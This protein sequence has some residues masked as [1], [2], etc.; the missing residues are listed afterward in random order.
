[1]NTII[2]RITFINVLLCSFLFIT[3]SNAQTNYKLKTHKI[4]IHG[5]S[6][7][8]DW[9]ESATKVEWS[10]KIK[11]NGTNIHDVVGVIV[12][13][14]V[15]SIKSTKGK[16]MDNKTYEA[17]KSDKNPDITYKLSGGSIKPGILASV[18]TL[19]MA[20]VSKKISMNINYKVLPNGDIH[21]TGSHTINMLDYGMEPPKAVM[22]TIKVGETVTVKLDLTLHQ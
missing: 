14:P 6:S 10:G 20:G 8:H 15:T 16:T 7:M 12:K 1:M 2:N 17:F 3:T 18:G 22:G 21:L 11:V 5:T 19:T 9:E 13:I 4:T